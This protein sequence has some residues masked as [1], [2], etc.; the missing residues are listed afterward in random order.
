M[1]KNTVFTL[2]H[3][4]RCIVIFCSSE[5]LVMRMGVFYGQ[6]EK[7]YPLCSSQ[8]DWDWEFGASGHGK[9]RVTLKQQ[10]GE[11][12]WSDGSCSTTDEES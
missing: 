5:L 11:E 1:G 8:I 7:Q 6:R 2:F 10:S 9:E 12:E 4:I 3:L